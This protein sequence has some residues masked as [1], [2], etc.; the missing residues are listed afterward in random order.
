M[1][2]ILDDLASG[3]SKS[4]LRKEKRVHKESEA[5]KKK[6]GPSGTD[7]THY[8]IAHNDAYH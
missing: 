4:K 6:M 8:N 5:F 3:K 7:I 2:T 1:T